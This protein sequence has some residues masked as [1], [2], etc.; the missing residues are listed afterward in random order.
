[1][2]PGD[3]VLFSPCWSLSLAAI[4]VGGLGEVVENQAGFLFGQIVNAATAT[5]NLGDLPF[6][7]RSGQLQALAHREQELNLL[8]RGRFFLPILGSRAIGWRGTRSRSSARSIRGAIAICGAISLAIC[9]A[10]RL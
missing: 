7:L 3:P 8:V 6:K 2:P 1:R 5:G 4:G 9:I 10:G